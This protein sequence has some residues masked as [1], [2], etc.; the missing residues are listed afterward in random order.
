MKEF[1]IVFVTD[2]LRGPGKV[3]VFDYHFH[4]VTI[5][6]PKASLESGFISR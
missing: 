6:S 5:F 2:G 3:I 4:Q 1:N